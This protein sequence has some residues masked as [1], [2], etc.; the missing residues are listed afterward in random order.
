M[1]DQVALVTECAIARRTNVRLLLWLWRHVIRIVIQVDVTLEQL[2]LSVGN[3]MENIRSVSVV[4][5]FMAREVILTGMP[6]RI[7]YIGMASDRCA[8]AYATQDAALKSTRTD[9]DHICNISR[10]RGFWYESAT[11]GIGIVSTRCN[12][13]VDNVLTL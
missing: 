10:L 5:Q 13:M 9:T 11:N 2:L 12:N 7:C 4:G 6:D 1:P 8:R 3:E